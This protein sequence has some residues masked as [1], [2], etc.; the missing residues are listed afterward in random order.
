[1]FEVLVLS[2][3]VF[4]DLGK[5][6]DL[7]QAMLGNSVP[8]GKKVHPVRHEVLSALLVSL[9]E[10]PLKPWVQEIYKPYG[11][12]FPWM[13]SWVAGGHHLK[14]HQDQPHL[15]RETDRLVRKQGTPSSLI[16]LGSHPDVQELLDM[17]PG[18]IGL[19]AKSLTLQNLSIPLEEE[20]DLN[21]VNLEGL[22]LDYIKT[23]EN[24]ARKLSRTEQKLLAF[25]K[26]VLIAADVAGSAF[27]LDTSDPQQELTAALSQTLSA[28]NLE[29]VINFKL[30]GEALR[31]FQEQVAQSTDSVTL[32]IA[33]CGSGKT[34]AA[35]AWAQQRATG[36]KLF[37]CYPTTG[38][39]SAGFEDYLLAQ[40]SIERTLIHGRSQVDL[41]RLLGTQEDKDYPIEE[42]Q[43]IESLKVWHQQV[44]A[45]TTDT[46]LGLIQNQRRG[47]FSFPAIASGAFVFD[48]IHN[49][50]AKLFGALLNFLDTF[51]YAPALLMSASIPPGR[52]EQLRKVLGPRLGKAITGEPNIET[53][54]RYLLQWLESCEDCWGKVQAALRAGKKVLWVANTIY[55]S[56][57]SGA[58]QIYD[59][60]KE[61]TLTPTLYHGRFR[62]RDRVDL[63]DQVLKLFQQQG[64]AMVTATQVCEMSLDISADLLVTAL[65]PF[66]SLIQRL[67]RLNRRAHDKPEEDRR[68]GE[69]LIYDFSCP[70]DRPYKTR[71]L[72]L[73]RQALA[74][75]LEKPLSQRQLAS[76]LA[77][78][79]QDEEISTYSAWLDGK[80]QS[81]QRPL[82]AGSDSLTI[83]LKQDLPEIKQYL[84]DRNIRPSSQ[85]VAAWTI[86]MLYYPGIHIDEYFAGYPVIGGHLVE[87]DEI[88]GARW[89]KKNWEI[90]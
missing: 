82:R 64:P 59:Q 87:Y 81:D 11:E 53:L 63:Q 48:E 57:R 88:R 25:A 41:E 3:A 79:Y 29:A 83:L 84:K 20:D 51:S 55:D 76:V 14:L 18:T 90:I 74:P 68:L 52:L 70:D 30:K 71:D 85:N 58:V 62:Y 86:P 37:F 31:N 17:I 42:N 4:H 1:K 43:R 7:F 40:S 46:I 32:T 72:E 39:A 61:R 9:L 75:L 28:H 10:S 49:Y 67:G 12:E 60:A 80:W 54:E 27:T 77:D 6:T 34:L 15:K 38:T 73:S 23:S 24:F 8:L 50:D 45:C 19:N 36:R 35:Y 16:F 89:R 65:A 2:A 5:A 44:I 33:G 56:S 13:I 66:N 26:A 21:A 22:I 47:L 69:C 78:L